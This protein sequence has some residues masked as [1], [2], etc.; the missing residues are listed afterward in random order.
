MFLTRRSFGLRIYKAR[1]GNDQTLPILPMGPSIRHGA[2][3]LGR[4]GV[5]PFRVDN[6]R[7]IARTCVDELPGGVSVLPYVN[8]VHLVP[9]R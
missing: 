5:D 1:Q 4:L 6:L 3:L 9:N 2:L 8:L 7:R